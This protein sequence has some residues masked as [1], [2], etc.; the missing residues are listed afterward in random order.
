MRGSYTWGASTYFAELGASTKHGY[1]TF[2]TAIKSL[3]QELGITGRIVRDSKRQNEADSFTK[4]ISVVN[5][6]TIFQFKWG[7]AG[8][9]SDAG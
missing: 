5:R 8:D 2:S 4:K 1:T 6:M 7:G 3:I 9:G